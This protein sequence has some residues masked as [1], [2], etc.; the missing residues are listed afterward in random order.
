VGT[1]TNLIDQPGITIRE[2]CLMT[3][4]NVGQ[5]TVITRIL[6]TPIATSIGT[7]VTTTYEV[8]FE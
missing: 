3:N 7:T 8:T 5:G 6:V 2:F 4:A 1:N